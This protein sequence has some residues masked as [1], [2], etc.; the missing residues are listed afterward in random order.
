[1]RLSNYVGNTPLIPIEFG[2]LT[3]WGKAEFINPG[4]SVKDR[5]ATYIINHAE[6]N[7]LIKSGDTLCEATSGNTGIAF[8]MLAAERGY[9]MY[10]IMPSNMSNERKQM[11]KFYGARL[12]EVD[13]G[14]FDGAI[15][16]RDEMCKKM[17]W[18]N[19]NQFHNPLNIEAHY[20]NTGP[21]LA[22]Q[23]TKGGAVVFDEPDAFI[24][25]TGTGGTIM[26]CGGYLKTLWPN[27]KI[28]AVEPAESP[29][30]SGGKQGLHG[31]QGIG[32]GS[33]F[34]VD[35]D[36][37]D[38]IKTVHTECAKTIAKY[39]ALKYGLFVGISAGA[40]V[41]ASFQWLRDNNKNNAITILCDRGER[42]FSCL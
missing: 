33:K 32:D 14:D 26:G 28:V 2:G 21:E 13:E 23:I 41:F 7:G 3:V 24:A 31:I 35:L 29:V 17:G 38:D 20:R 39:L 15:A 9:K 40:N 16:L 36:F 37:V 42:Y 25:G 6:E 11:L 4:G 27:I 34:L 5:M 22:N 1:M 18:F 8:A 10:I 19:C 30:M 12:I